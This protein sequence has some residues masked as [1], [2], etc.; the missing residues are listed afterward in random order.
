MVYFKNLNTGQ[1]LFSPPEDPAAAA[2]QMGDADLFAAEAAEAAEA[3]RFVAEQVE[4]AGRQELEQRQA[5][6]AIEAAEKAEREQELAFLAVGESSVILM[7]P[8]FYPC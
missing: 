6:E 5:A 8:P 2:Q 3:A 7:T 1:G 4:A